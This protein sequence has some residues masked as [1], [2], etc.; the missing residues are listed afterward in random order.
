MKKVE[1]LASSVSA[2]GASAV[3]AA[4]KVISTSKYDSAK[5]AGD[6][7]M[8]VMAVAN[9]AISKHKNDTAADARNLAADAEKTP[10]SNE[11]ED[12]NTDSNPDSENKEAI[13]E[14]AAAL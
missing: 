1:A 12:E 11:E 14:M 3:S 7:S 6:V 8:E 4:N 5:S 13:A 10:S 2:M 9:E